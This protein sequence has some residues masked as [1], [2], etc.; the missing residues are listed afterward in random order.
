MF[1]TLLI[2]FVFIMLIRGISNLFLQKPGGK[3]SG[4]RFFYQTIKNAR[5]QQK[6]QQA[7]QK[8]NQ[9]GKVEK[10][11]IDNIEEAEYEEIKEDDSET[12]K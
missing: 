3:K 2:V 10:G 9:N 11:N 4:F 12:P 6:E 1:K 7:Q 8:R 5:N